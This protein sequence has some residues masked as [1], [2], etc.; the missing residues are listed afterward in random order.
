MSISNT[1]I[2]L[3]VKNEEIDLKNCIESIKKVSN[4]RIIVVDNNSTD[5][6]KEIALELNLEVIE[7]KRNGKGNVIKKI[8]KEANSKY[9]FFT[10]ADN[11]YDLSQ[12]NKH[13]EL[14]EKNNLDMIVGKRIY[15]KKY[16]K[17][18]ERKISNRLF[19]LLFK[20]LIGGKFS[21]VCSGYRLIRLEKF[22]NYDL[23]SSGFEIETEI[24]ILAVKN[25]LKY[26]EE[27]ISYRERVNSI[28][29]LKTFS[30]SSKIILFL[31]KNSFKF[32]RIYLI[33][34]L[35]LMMIVL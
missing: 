29:K 8:L 4:D 23:I 21:D 18:I 14:M 32:I 30:D 7:E 24:N 5:R 12:L 9:V 19:N 27:P 3:P 6:S 2:F 13:K 20:L 26:N 28:S 17:R 34:L 10:D 33:S 16:L 15:E 31:I 25:K 22:K 1:E 11:T 35:I